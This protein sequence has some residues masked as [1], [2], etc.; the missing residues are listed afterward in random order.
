MCQSHNKLKPYE[1]CV[2]VRSVAENTTF[3]LIFPH[4]PDGIGNHPIALH[5][6]RLPLFL[7]VEQFLGGWVVN[8]IIGF[9]P[10]H[11]RLDSMV[12]IDV[13]HLRAPVLHKEQPIGMNSIIRPVFSAP[14][15]PRACKDSTSFLGKAR[16]CRML[17]MLASFFFQPVQ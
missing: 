5:D 4:A 8:T 14:F 6:F 2:L 3:L 16:H 13:L 12:Q 17:K 15:K 9:H 10:T 1:E 7:S 11:D